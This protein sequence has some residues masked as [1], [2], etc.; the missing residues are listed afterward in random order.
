MVIRVLDNLLEQSAHTVWI[1]LFS[2]LKISSTA[3]LLKA[4]FLIM[5]T[6]TDILHSRCYFQLYS[7]LSITH[8]YFK[9]YFFLQNIHPGLTGAQMK[10]NRSNKYSPNIT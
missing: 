9:E 8:Q 5:N 7:G 3:T 4:T 2:E 6:H 1:Q 10:D